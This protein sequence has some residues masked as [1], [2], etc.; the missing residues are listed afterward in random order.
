MC[1]NVNLYVRGTNLK[2][3]KPRPTS[4][5]ERENREK[6]NEKR[7]KERPLIE[8]EKKPFS[9]EDSSGGLMSLRCQYVSE[10]EL[11]IDELTHHEFGHCRVL[12][13]KSRAINTTICNAVM[14]TR[15]NTLTSPARSDGLMD[16]L[17]D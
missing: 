3:G 7:I 5:R 10:S 2:N 11:I 9:L 12:E 1:Q 6:E 17:T 13:Q 8:R 4:I 16:R 14:E 15:D